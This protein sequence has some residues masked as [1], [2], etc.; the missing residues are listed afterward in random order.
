M[1]T[2]A[3]IRA[4]FVSAFLAVFPKL[5]M[6]MLGQRKKFL[7]TPAPLKETRG[8]QIGKKSQ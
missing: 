1:Q 2:F 8:T 4:C 3:Y 5:Y 7:G 6:Y